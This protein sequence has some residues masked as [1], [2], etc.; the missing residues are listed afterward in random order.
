[1][2]LPSGYT[3]LE[4]IESSGAQYIDT[5]FKPNQDTRVVCD[6]QITAD[7]GAHQT[8]FG[9]RNETSAGQYVV[10]YTG[11]KTPAVFRSDFASSQVSYSTGVLMSDR[12]TVDKNKN[13]CTI[14]TETVTNTS[15]AF[16]CSYNL[17]L[18]A[19]NSVGEVGNQTSMLFYSC[20]IYD[21]GTLTRAYTPCK[22]DA[23]AV[24]LY[25]AVTGSFYEN[26]GTGVFT[27]GPEVAQPD[28]PLP[29]ISV[30]VTSTTADSV[31]IAWNAVDG[32][33]GYRVYRDGVLLDSVTALTYTDTVPTA[34]ARHIYAVVAYDVDGDLAVGT[35]VG[36][37]IW[38]PGL[39]PLVTDRGPGACYYAEDLNR[40]GT[41]IE[42]SADRLHEFGFAVAVS[43]KTDWTVQ[44][45]PVKSQMERYLADVSALRDSLPLPVETP[46][47][48]ASMAG[49]DYNGANNIEKILL[50]LDRMLDNTAA[51]WYYTGDLYAGEI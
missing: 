22:D 27:A 9:C 24:G 4:Y 37:S 11:H 21:N 18:F 12:H 51:A 31:T 3:Q 33:A 15:E 20:Q 1:M 13:V 43:P 35:A 25:D 17:L 23:G 7:N 32:A 38:L 50:Q 47:V 45:L 6:F 28:I 8:P 42:Y 49:L 29:E 36:A 5:W 41:A 2:S 16:Q 26:S 30:S 19:N 46:Q 10:G 44:G 40:V 34:Y 48:P 39:P 14:G